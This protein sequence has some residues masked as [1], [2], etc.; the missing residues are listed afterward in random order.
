MDRMAPDE[1]IFREHL[2][3]DAFL[4]GVARGKW[5]LE[6]GQ[7][8]ITWPHPI[9]QIQARQKVTG[10]R[11]L[12]L[13]FDLQNY[14]Q[15]APTSCPWNLESNSPLDPALWPIGPG[16]VSRVFN[17]NWN[18]SA[19][20]APCDRLAMV[21]HES[22]SGTHSAWWWNPTFSFVRYLEF[23]FICLNPCG[24]EE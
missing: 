5:R 4:A 19:L 6:H 11:D 23:V 17:P 14:P 15:Q 12:L 24:N 8:G 18:R 22:W 13:R 16:N 9:F 7:E 21:N 1:S 10:G 2:H 3:S 20:Y